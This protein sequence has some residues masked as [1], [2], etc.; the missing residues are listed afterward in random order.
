MNSVQYLM[1]QLLGG[2]LAGMGGVWLKVVFLAFLMAIPVFRPER[3]KTL[4]LYR[5]A[6]VCFGISV[7]IPGAASL[8]TI[9][10]VLPGAGPGLNNGSATLFG[11][12]LVQMLNAG[13]P[14]LFG[15]SIIFA[16]KAIVPA[17][18]P[19]VNYRR[20][21]Q[22]QPDVSVDSETTPDDNAQR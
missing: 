4:G 14:I 10:A 22:L 1:M 2:G 6:C 7:I 11:P 12:G 20:T 3:I 8:L 18:I 15:L 5:R 9:A 19:P 16:L 13:G 21:V 17:F